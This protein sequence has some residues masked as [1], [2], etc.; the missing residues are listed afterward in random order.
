MV[1][2]AD[3]TKNMGVMQEARVLVEQVF[4][5]MM[6]DEGFDVDMRWAGALMDGDQSLE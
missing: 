5:I 3:A 2:R 4:K 6:R 1:L